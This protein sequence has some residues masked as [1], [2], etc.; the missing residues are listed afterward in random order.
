MKMTYY[1][2]FYNLFEFYKD[3]SQKKYEAVISF[4]EANKTLLEKDEE[5]KWLAKICEEGSLNLLHYCEKTFPSFSLYDQSK[6]VEHYSNLAF[7][8]AILSGNLDIIDYFIQHPDLH[9]FLK[10][11]N[12][13]QDV[14]RTIEQYKDN[15]KRRNTLDYDKITNY[16]NL[17]FYLAEKVPRVCSYIFDFASRNNKNDE[18]SFILS[19]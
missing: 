2:D 4:I 1:S 9:Y 7:L 16:K 11:D 18:I 5:R 13:E 6:S 15:H 8:R 17:T 3:N 12:I 14:G 19:S 10:R